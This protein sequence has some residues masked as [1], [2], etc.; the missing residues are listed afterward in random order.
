MEN[1]SGTLAA[2]GVDLPPEP[3]PLTGPEQRVMRRCLS[4]LGVLG[5]GSMLGV[6]SSLYLVNTYPLLLIALSPL[7]RHLVLV[8]PVVDPVAFVVLAVG[9][10]MIFYLP[11]FHLGRALGP[12]GIPW[13]EARAARFGYFVR[14]LERLFARASHTVV[15]AMAGPTVS[16]LAGISGMRAGVFAAL[17][18][19]GLV[20]RMLLLLAFADWLRG[21]IE[22]VR[23]LIYAYWVP[24]TVAI[25]AI[26]ALQRWRRRSAAPAA[27]S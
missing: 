16:G 26:I 18:A 22:A 7:G 14:W 25:V 21:P 17:A 8:A 19:A 23:A 3:R 9:R 11:C 20:A 2:G 15:F 12:A 10:R 6:A 13:I 4:A 5:T 27:A 24:G 1:V